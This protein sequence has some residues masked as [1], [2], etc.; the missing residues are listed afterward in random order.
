M[1]VLDRIEKAEIRDLLGKGWL[2]HD[3]LWFFLTCRAFGIDKANALNR[4]AIKSLAP[5]ETERAKRVLKIGKATIDNFPELMDFIAA[6]LEVTLPDSVFTKFHLS[7]PSKDL[8]HWEWEKGQCFA[9]KGM[10]QN[11]LIDQYHCGVIYRIECWLE[12]LGV[13][14]SMR[15]KIDACLMNEE[16]A[17]GGNIQVFF[18][19]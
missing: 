6:A 16:G 10:K 14:Y 7:S 4:A 17:C 13:R 3:G 18:P 19:G 15:T 9:F 12:A 2:T 1:S 5:I 8:I 11:G